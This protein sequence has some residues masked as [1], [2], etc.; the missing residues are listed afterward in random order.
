MEVVV[1]ENFYKK[2]K[3]LPKEIQIR[4]YSILRLLEQFPFI[5]LDIKKLRGKERM[6]RVRIGKYRILFV[7]VDN[8][9]YVS[10]IS[11][12]EKVKY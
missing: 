1:E 11:I 4:V 3:K 10:D 7:L 9:I 12:R 6:F 8:K 2:L 5:R